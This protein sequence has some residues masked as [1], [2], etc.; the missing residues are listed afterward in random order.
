VA[1]QVGG[2]YDPSEIADWIHENAITSAK[3]I[4]ATTVENLQAYLDGND[5]PDA[6]DAYFDGQVD[7]R[8]DS[9]STS[10]VAM[11]AGLASLSS[12]SQNGAA[13]KTWITS[14][15]NPRP[16]HAQMNGETVGIDDAFSNGMNM[17]GDPSGGADEVAGCTCDV[18]FDF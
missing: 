2:S 10:R 12:A 14:G 16:S 8:A 11:V 4:N 15:R 3:A 18:S 13:T 9:I 7:A 1:K 6:V 5:D 17:P